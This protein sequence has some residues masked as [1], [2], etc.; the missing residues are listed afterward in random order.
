M[1]NIEVYCVTDLDEDKTIKNYRK[2]SIKQQPIFAFIREI[3]DY[4]RRIATFF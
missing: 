3:F 4:P 2:D 1:T